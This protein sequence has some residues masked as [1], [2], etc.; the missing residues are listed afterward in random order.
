MCNGNHAAGI[1]KFATIIGSIGITPQQITQQSGIGNIAGSFKVGDL[2]QFLQLRR[3]PAMHAQDSFVNHSGGGQ[4]IKDIGKD[5]PQ[6]DGIPPFAFVVKSI[7]A[8]DT[9]TFVIAS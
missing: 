9:G 1:V 8:I 5:F 4:T 6:F 7:N 2:V 3:Q